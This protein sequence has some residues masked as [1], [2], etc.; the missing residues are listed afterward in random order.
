VNTPIDSLQVC[1]SDA[2]ARERAL[3]AKLA[4]A[5]AHHARA[6]EQRRA[7]LIEGEAELDAKTLAD[8]DSKVVQAAS[9]VAGLT[10][11]L[12]LASEQASE[13][14]RQ[15]AD[16]QDLAQRQAETAK[17]RTLVADIDK[18]V[19]VLSEVAVACEQ[20][21]QAAGLFC[22]EALAA[23]R[24][25]RSSQRDMQVYNEQAVNDLKSY[26]A[27]LERGGKLRRP[28]SNEPTPKIRT[29]KPLLRRIYFTEFVRWTIDSQTITARQFSTNDLPPHLADKAVQCGLAIEQDDPKTA[30]L[31]R[32]LGDGWAIPADPA[33]CI[34]LIELAPDVDLHRVSPQVILAHQAK[35]STA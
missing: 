16:A 26:A 24:L 33:I 15:L 3:Q 19:E 5:E 29:P 35:A 17:V 11:A 1:L 10:D 7:Y 25:M 4:L 32:T 12:R 31:R 9:A 8:L 13:A 27:A 21:L 20:A 34:D 14:Q 2:K 22:P 28:I 18:A 23:A 6:S 30:T